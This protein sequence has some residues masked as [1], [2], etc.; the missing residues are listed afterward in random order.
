[1]STKKNVKFEPKNKSTS[2]NSDDMDS[3]V[4]EEQDDEKDVVSVE[5]EEEDEK[6]EEEEDEKEEEEG[7]VEGEEV[8]EVTEEEEKEEEIDDEADEADENDEETDNY[9]IESTKSGL[10]EKS[11]KSCM[12]KKNYKSN[13]SSEDD[14][15]LEFDDDDVKIN[16]TILP[17]NK[18]I[19]KDIMTKYERV[20]LLSDRT[21]QLTRGAKPLVKNTTGLMAKQIAELELENNTIPLKI[22]RPLPNGKFEIWFTKEFKN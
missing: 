22:R 4:S 8:S 17:A 11:K 3:L 5:E 6:E 19:T 7:E 21:T 15:V 2:S 14:P 13:E 9:D 16:L 18:R 10:Y 12:Y 20:R 1:M